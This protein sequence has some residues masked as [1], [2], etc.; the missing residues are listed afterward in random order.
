[1]VKAE[2]VVNKHIVPTES[3]LNS[4]NENLKRGCFEYQKQVCY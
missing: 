4:G 2:S 3:I 1:L